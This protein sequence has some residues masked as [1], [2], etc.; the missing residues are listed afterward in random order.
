[1]VARTFTNR[2]TLSLRFPA[3]SY[4]FLPRSFF[5]VTIFFSC[6]HTLVFTNLPYLPLR[7]QH[8]A[9]VTTITPLT[10]ISR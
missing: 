4:F 1:M 7:L 2:L 8:R 3:Y 5:S 10:E 6:F 9:L